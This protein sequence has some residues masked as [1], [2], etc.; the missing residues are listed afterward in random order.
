MVSKE[1]AKNIH[2][3]NP[4]AKIIILLREPVS[5]VHSLHQQY[6]NNGT[7][8]EPDFE[9]A[10]AKEPARR[11]GQALPPHTRAPSHLFYSERIKYTDHIQRFL[12]QFPEENVLILLNEEFAA[13]NKAMY[14]EVVRFLEIDPNFTPIFSH[15]HGSKVPRYPRLHRLLNNSH[16]KQLV[17]KVTGSQKYDRLKQTATAVFL[18]R[19]PRDK[20]DPALRQKLKKAYTPEVIKIAKLINRPDLRHIWNY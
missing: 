2:D 19:K 1:A 14:R 11:H 10:V 4:D 18:K 13:D 12:D 3:Y 6:V 17:R 20:L 7:E 15:I 8:D 16:F 5:F 9:K